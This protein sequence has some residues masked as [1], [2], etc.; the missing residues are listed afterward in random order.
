MNH[1]KEVLPP[2]GASSVD[3][4]ALGL[5]LSSLMVWWFFFCFAHGID[6]FNGGVPGIA[7]MGGKQPVEPV[8]SRSR[9]QPLKLRRLVVW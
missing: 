1:K 3:W 5:E 8:V 7:E 6:N 4:W 2:A 9:W